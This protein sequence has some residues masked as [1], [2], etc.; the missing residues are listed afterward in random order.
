MNAHNESR[1]GVLAILAVGF[2][3]ISLVYWWAG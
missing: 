3:L 2:C 1:L